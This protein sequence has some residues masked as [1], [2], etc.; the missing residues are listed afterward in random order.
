MRLPPQPTPRRLSSDMVQFPTWHP[1][2]KERGLLSTSTDITI[3]RTQTV[4]STRRSLNTFTSGR[5]VRRQRRYTSHRSCG[6]YPLSAISHIAHLNEIT[7]KAIVTIRRRSGRRY[8]NL[9]YSIGFG[10]SSGRSTG[11]LA[12]PRKESFIQQKSTS[13]QD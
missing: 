8:G 3:L 5:T 2:C 7:F 13:P 12:K 10:K 1:K 4:T 11:V 9:T 6:H